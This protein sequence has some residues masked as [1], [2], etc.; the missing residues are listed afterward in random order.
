[1]DFIAKGEPFFTE[2]SLEFVFVTTKLDISVAVTASFSF[3]THPLHS[4]PCLID[5]H[6]TRDNSPRS[7]NEELGPT[8]SLRGPLELVSDY[9]CGYGSLKS[10]AETPTVGPRGDTPRA[11]KHTYASIHKRL[12][13][14][15]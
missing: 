13:I 12:R 3:T 9:G 6:E 14:R 7:G 1:M 15:D 11:R 5:S 4:R 8:G 2:L 10:V